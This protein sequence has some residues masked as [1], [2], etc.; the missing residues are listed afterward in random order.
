[1]TPSLRD[2]PF[3]ENLTLGLRR[4]QVLRYGEN[5]HQAAALYTWGRA[6]PHANEPSSEAGGAGAGAN[7]H[8]PALPGPPPVAGAR[9]R[10]GKELGY[11]NLL[12]LDAALATVASF[13]PPATAIIKHTNPCGL[14]CGDTLLE[15]YRRAHAGDPVS[16]YGGVIGFNR[17][18]DEAAA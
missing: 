2:E 15:S 4:A 3:P 13:L 9:A 17:E 16:A 10:H 18:V 6:Q 5:P 8:A 14:A 12:D 1:A 7:G 11:N